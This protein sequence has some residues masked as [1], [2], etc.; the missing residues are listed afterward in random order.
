MVLFSTISDLWSPLS[1]VLAKSFTAFSELG[2]PFLLALVV[3]IMY[4]CLLLNVLAKL[5]LVKK[6][7]A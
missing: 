6:L 1:M 3:P 7:S 4:V 5:T 2:H